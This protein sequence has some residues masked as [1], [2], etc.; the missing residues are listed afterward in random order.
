VVS[1]I[2]K[3]FVNSKLCIQDLITYITKKVNPLRVGEIVKGKGKS[4]ILIHDFSSDKKIS[5]G[6]LWVQLS[7]PTL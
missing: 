3:V 7:E 6:P 1:H 5:R 2:V 4:M